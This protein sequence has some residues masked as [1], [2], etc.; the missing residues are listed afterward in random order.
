MSNIVQL[1]D[2]KEGEFRIPKTS[3]QEDTI[4]LYLNKYE[5]HYLIRLFGFDLY[6]LFIDNLL[7]GVPTAQRF[8][9]V[10]DSFV[11]Q[12]DCDFCDSQGMKEMIEGF[13]YFHYVRHTFTRNTTNGVK[14]TAS[15]N[16]ISL[17]TVSADLTTRY[18]N[19]VQTFRCIQ[20]RMCRKSS[21]YPEFKGV[22]VEEILP[23]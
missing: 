7:L 21:I 22:K 6:T 12:D 15:E 2:F 20:E 8:I 9:D 10:F 4:Q 5:R 1:L 11:D 17:E 23:I 18:N 16:A 14:Q 19:S 13:I 3:W